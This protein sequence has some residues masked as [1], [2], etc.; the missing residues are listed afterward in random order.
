MR[1]LAPP[2]REELTRA[3]QRALTLVQ[4]AKSTWTRADFL[5][6]LA[7]VLPAETRAMAPEAAV[8]LLHEL[9]DEALA[10]AVEQVVC[11]EAPQWPPLPDY[12]RREL[13]G[14][15]VYTRPGTTRYATRVQLAMEEQLLRE[16]QRQGAPHLTRE[17]AA[18]L[19]G[20]DAGDAGGAAVASGRRN[21]APS[22]TQARA[23]AW[24]RARRCITR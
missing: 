10:G 23:C 2:A 7:L 13:D 17:Q 6:Q 19:L 22:V 1:S 3:V 24:T 14:R 21:R 20:A 15:S 18:A 11:L 16:A 9:A 5:K 12:L 8:A 4:A